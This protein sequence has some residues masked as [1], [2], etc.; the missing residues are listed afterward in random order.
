VHINSGFIGSMAIKHHAV[1]PA[2]HMYG[3]RVEA[4]I[5]A[6]SYSSAYVTA[7]WKPLEQNNR[8]WRPVRRA[9]DT[10]KSEHAY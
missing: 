4:L 1:P 2:P 9:P 7:D 5:K 3:I 6:K 8:W 10:K